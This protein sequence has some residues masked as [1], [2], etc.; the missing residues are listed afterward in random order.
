[1]LTGMGDLL[2]LAGDADLVFPE[3]FLKPLG[4]GSFLRGLSGARF[5]SL[6]RESGSTMHA[7]G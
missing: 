2:R 3:V 1:M 5:R 4:L 6:A 7:S